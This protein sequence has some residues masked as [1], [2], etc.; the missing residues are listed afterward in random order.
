MSK[1]LKRSLADRL[2]SS[3]MVFPY[4]ILFALTTGPLLYSLVSSLYHRILYDPSNVKF[5]GLGNYISMLRSEN[6]WNAMRNTGYQVGVTVTLQFVIG[7]VCALLLSR[8][9]I[10]MSKIART[11][12]LLPMMTTPVVVGL[13]WR[14]LYNPDM[15]MINF[16]LGLPGF[17]GPNWLGS[18][19]WAMPAMILTDLWLSTPFMAVI[20][21]AGI[22]SLPREPF[23]A[24]LVDGAN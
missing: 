24:A 3:V 10:F 21:F 17:G 16:V 2:F 23:E 9:D 1:H 12:F 19:D 8:D 18:A 22:Q 4:V 14:M 15:G 6:F 11:L 5:I 13:A 7:L 20:L